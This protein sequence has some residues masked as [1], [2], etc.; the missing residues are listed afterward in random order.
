VSI[1]PCQLRALINEHLALFVDPRF[2]RKGSPQQH[3]G[4]DA[5]VTP[6][7]MMV[8]LQ[9]DKGSFLESHGYSWALDASAYN[10][11]FEALLQWRLLNTLSDIQ[12]DHP[13]LE[14]CTNLVVRVLPTSCA[15][16]H[17]RQVEQYHVIVLTSGYLSAFKGFIRLW[18]RG[19]AWSS[20]NKSSAHEL[21]RVRC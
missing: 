7:E 16:P 21:P 6:M 10:S 14:R 12:A 8:T 19:C 3:G 20:G 11:E 9:K 13:A 1:K 5:W 15:R 17:L 2:E 18:L 4:A